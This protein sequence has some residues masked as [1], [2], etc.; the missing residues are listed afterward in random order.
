MLGILPIPRL[1]RNM[2]FKVDKR[3]GKLA[4]APRTPKAP[5][6]SV[7]RITIIFLTGAFIVISS[8]DFEPGS[9]P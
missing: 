9:P 5:T 6:A 4:D 2:R 1:R 3:I 7:P 8:S